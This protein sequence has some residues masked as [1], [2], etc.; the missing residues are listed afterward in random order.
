MRAPPGRARGGGQDGLRGWRAGPPGKRPGALPTE[1]QA[2]PHALPPPSLGDLSGTDWE[3]GPMV[4][5]AIWP[6]LQLLRTTVHT[7]EPGLQEPPLPQ[8]LPLCALP[9]CFCT[10]LSRGP[11]AGGEN[12]PTPR[13]KPAEQRSHPKKPLPTCRL[14]HLDSVPQALRTPSLSGSRLCRAPLFLIPTEEPTGGGVFLQGGSPRGSP[15]SPGSQFP[16]PSTAPLPIAGLGLGVDRSG[17]T[18]ACMEG[19]GGRAEGSGLA[20]PLRVFFCEGEGGAW[21]GLQL[22]APSCLPA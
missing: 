8:Q 1:R 17:H 22:R 5:E 21:K 14:G 19:L 18:C 10:P 3:G 11:V 16:Q 15:G 9:F 13:E 4:P 6:T 7:G 12:P 20:H 2:A